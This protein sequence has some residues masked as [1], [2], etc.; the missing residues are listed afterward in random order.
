MPVKVVFQNIEQRV[1]SS[2]LYLHREHKKCQG[3]LR[4]EDVTVGCKVDDFL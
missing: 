3:Y 2:T 4:V 1:I